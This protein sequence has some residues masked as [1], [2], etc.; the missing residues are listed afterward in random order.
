M[1]PYRIK[2][3]GLK[4]PPKGISELLSRCG[5]HYLD[6]FLFIVHNKSY[7]LLDTLHVPS[8]LSIT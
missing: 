5:G 1:M 7:H 4:A 2:S 8:L 3:Q 6:I